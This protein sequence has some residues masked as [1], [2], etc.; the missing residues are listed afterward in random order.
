MS[1]P[2]PVDDID[3]L[4]R[5]FEILKDLP[6]PEQQRVFRFAADKLGMPP[7]A[8]SGS[9]LSAAEELAAAR[10]QSDV[11]PPGD[12]RSFLAAKAPKG[13]VQTA[14]TLAYFV[15]F[16]APDDYR[17]ETIGASDLQDWCR[18]AG[19]K[20][21]PNPGRVLHNARALGYLDRTDRGRFAINA[22][23]ENLVA[24]TLP[25][26][27]NAETNNGRISRRRRTRV[28]GRAK[29]TGRA[30]KRK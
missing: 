12:V 11:A 10:D 4:R 27:A 24:M 28:A 25:R 29:F 21:F 20:R 18:Q 1:D 5:V 16:L 14:V 19:A 17:S 9:P 22:V 13:D 8:A 6:L 26:G 7:A 23:G 3:V 30:A 15:R 2:Q